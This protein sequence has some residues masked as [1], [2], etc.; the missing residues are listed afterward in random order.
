MNQN[1]LN[2]EIETV[3]A[4]EEELILTDEELE[5]KVVGGLGFGGSGE[6][7]LESRKREVVVGGYY[8]LDTEGSNIN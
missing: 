8:D 3:N 2:K 1:Y 6:V 7:N 4:D 5:K